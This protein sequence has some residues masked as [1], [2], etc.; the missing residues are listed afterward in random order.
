MEN[1]NHY[2]YIISPFSTS[3]EIINSD[4]YSSWK[5]LNPYGDQSNNLSYED[6]LGTDNNDPL[7]P[8]FPF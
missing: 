4:D 8:L 1:N 5:E 2:P 6:E 7:N 3:L